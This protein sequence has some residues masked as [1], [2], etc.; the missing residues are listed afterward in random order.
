M[1]Y[2]C[3]APTVGGFVQQVA[4]S[5]LTHGYLFYVS[6]VIPEA[7]DPGAVDEKLIDKY[8]IAVSRWS[9]A[10]RKRTG[11]ASVQYLRHRRFFLIT[12]TH[13]EHDFFA[14]EAACIRDFR[15]TPLKFGSYA[16]SHRGGHPHVRIAQ[17]TML[18]LKAY[19]LERSCHRSAERLGR[20][21]ASLPFEPWAP[22]RRQLLQLLSAVNAKRREAGFEPV[23]RE[24]LRFRRR[25]YRV[26][27]DDEDDL[28]RVA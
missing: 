10:R 1:K 27:D 20:E 19:F 13:G 16:I 22:V 3:E 8:G 15:E 25:I 21:F 14:E 17:P 7:K 5:Y 9:R 6:G 2:R 12:A 18:D 11:V 4:V 23:P 26:F 28:D 24:C